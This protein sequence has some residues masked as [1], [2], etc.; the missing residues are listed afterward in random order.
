MS[1]MKLSIRTGPNEP[2]V[3]VPMNNVPMEDFNPYN[4]GRI[5]GLKTAINIVSNVLGG[6]HPTQAD[7]DDPRRVVLI[8][9]TK[10]RIGKIL[11]DEL[12]A[13]LQDVKL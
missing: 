11:T 10:D 1:D 4:Q 3:D 6:F 7:Y 5:A 13:A 8:N 2:W 9:V 12:N